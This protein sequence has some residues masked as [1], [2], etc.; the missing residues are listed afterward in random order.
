MQIYVVSDPASRTVEFLC[1]RHR[2]EILLQR[3][4]L[5]WAEARV[6][7]YCSRCPHV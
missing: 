5:L 6:R 3:T 2:D 4:G 7:T 1:M